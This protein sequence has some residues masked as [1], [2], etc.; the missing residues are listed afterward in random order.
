MRCF[1]DF[2]LDS[3]LCLEQGATPLVL[4]CPNDSFALTLAN[5]EHDPALPQSVCRRISCSTHP[6]LKTFESLR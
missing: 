4:K 6:H 3:D 5:A 1:A 2:I